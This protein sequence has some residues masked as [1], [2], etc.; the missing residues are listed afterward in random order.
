MFK[1]FLRYLNG[2]VRIGVY[3]AA[4]E[5]F[6][7][8]C[9]RH[10]IALYDM[11]RIQVDE[12]HVT[13]LV[14]DFRR[15]RALMGRTGCRVRL[16]RRRGA[17]FLVYR[18]RKRYMLFGGV[19]LFGGLCW[20]LMSFLW[21]I[22]M[23]VPNGISGYELEQNLA[24]LGV[25]PGA[26]IG[27]IDARA[28]RSEMMYRMPELAF[29]SI[30]LHGNRLEVEAYVRRAKPQMVDRDLPTSVYAVKPGLITKMTVTEG[31]PAK[32]VGETVAQGEMLVSS[33]KLPTGE[34]GTARKSHASAEVEA[35]TWY[36]IT[37]RRPPQTAVK[38]YN[39]R[40]KTRY[41]LVFG[42][43]RLNL[44]LGSS[45]SPD[46]C[47]KTVSESKIVIAGSLEIPICLEQ[48]TLRYYE[49]R[50]VSPNAETMREQMEQAALERLKAQIDGSVTAHSASF[51]ELPGGGFELTLYAECLEQIGQE[52]VDTQEL[53][54]PE[55]A[56]KAEP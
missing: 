12:L 4:V 11:E 51:R 53:P 43:R 31:T 1:D 34:Q 9:S 40:G 20:V 33:I 13:I 37:E 19:L 5:R 10:D 39:G 16:L 22:H 15:L 32:K 7:N 36:T 52:A 28:V 55:A 24:A 56:E 26:Y 45:I 23:T 41:A 3:G 25:H 14:A 35:R 46:D 48:Q 44:F 38:Q 8:L 2:T 21:V 17:P 29:I 42:K 54:A 49:G 30:N 47:D 6:L 18:F 50:A 27:S